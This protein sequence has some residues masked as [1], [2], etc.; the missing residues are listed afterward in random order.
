MKEKNR[1][2]N[3]GIFAHVDAGKTTITENILYQTGVIKTVGRVDNGNTQTDTM[4]LERKRGISIRSATTSFTLNNQ[5]VNLI[6]T[7]G[8]IDFISEVERVLHVL[9][10][11]VLV[12]S[13][14]EGVQAQTKVLW[15]ALRTLEI[16]TIIFVNKLDRLGAVTKT[17]LDEVKSAL[18]NDVIVMQESQNEGC[19]DLTVKGRVDYKEVLEVLAEYDEELEEAYISDSFVSEELLEEKISSYTQ[20]GKCFP[21]YL[22][23]ALLKVGVSEL[24]E[25]IMKQFKVNTESKEKELA[26]YVFKI[27]KEVNQKICYVRVFDGVLNNREDVEISNKGFTCK[28]KNLKSIENGEMKMVDSIPQGD[29]GIVYGF[30]QVEIGDIVGRRTEKLKSYKIP[31][32]VFSSKVTPTNLGD[33]PRLVSVLTDLSNQDPLLDFKKNPINNELSISL[34]GQIQREVL[35]SLLMEEFEIEVELTPPEIIY[36]EKP[37]GTGF[38]HLH[39]KREQPYPAGIALRVEPLPFG[40]G[41]EFES[42]VSLG[43]IIQPFQNAVRESVINAAKEGLMGWEVTDILVTFTD[44]YFNS[45]DSTASSFRKLTPMVFMEAL[46]VAETTVLEPRYDFTVTINECDLGRVTYDLRK[47]RAVIKEQFFK[48]SNVI[49]QGVI[50]VQTSSNYS[51]ELASQT[52]GKGVF[53]TVFSGYYESDEEITKTKERTTVNP[54]HRGMY[55]RSV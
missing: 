13:G 14:R 36:K 12:I 53:E 10:C 32:T 39:Y 54:M 37:R 21:V 28:V 40:S 35:T 23:S 48:G 29:I 41:I 30:E 2:I 49:I 22:G 55:I 20:L 8:H 50:P 4:E 25:G 34:I 6:D 16:P 7:P 3:L 44:A 18:S 26:G 17:V 31:K 1:A 5:K 19:G 42:E 9:D 46:T 11:A 24:L 15:R 51:I 52:K 33:L 38:A 47:M 43:Y 45:V 27:E